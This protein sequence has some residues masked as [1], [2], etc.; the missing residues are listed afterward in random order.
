MNQQPAASPLLHRLLFA[1]FI[2]FFTGLIFSFRA[3]SSMS[4]G[5]LIV[6]GILF[7]R[8]QEGKFINKRCKELF[9]AACLLYFLFLLLSESIT[10]TTSEGWRQVVLKTGLVFTPL[11][12]CCTAAFITISRE[13]LLVA[14]SLLLTAACLYC[15]ALA[16]RYYY[17]HG[18]SSHFFY[19]SLVH[20]LKQH[21][22]YFS[23]L[24]FF[25]LL[26]LLDT[27]KKKEYLFPSAIQF[28]MMSFFVI[29]L[30]LLSS[31][32]VILIFAVYLIYYLFTTG[33]LLHR[34]K[35]VTGSVVLVVLASATLLFATRNPVSKRFTELLQGNISLIEKE[36]FQRADYFNG[37]QFRLLQWKLVPEILQ[38]NKSWWT[39][40]GAGNAQPL[41]AK[42]Y[43]E[44]NMYGGIPGSDDTGY[45]LYNTHNQL[46]ESV[47]KNGIPG[48]LFL[49]F[50][51]FALL[52]M[53]VL[54][55]RQVL[56]FTILLL[57]LYSS[58]ESILETQYGI[59]IFTFF[60]LF[61]A[62]D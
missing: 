30:V 22:V 59:L 42:K 10:N 1:A 17:I 18:D 60:P 61:Y 37:L 49:L 43:M 20:P 2:I 8:Q 24:V 46:L 28:G 5:V 50:I 11:A 55:K 45:L 39:G 12:V 51:C 21:A 23:L 41:L 32:L 19:H 54:K 16:F 26:Y 4:T 52:R 6:L 27:L 56:S 57:L 9:P 53:A 35:I 47:L 25:G 38:D 62:P 31:K 7:N 14:Y 34:N 40:V 33:K 3:V 58:S 36:H 13:K 44:K 15:L 29:F 48:A